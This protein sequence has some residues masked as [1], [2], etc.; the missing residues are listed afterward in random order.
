MG[1]EERIIPEVQDPLDSPPLSRRSFL[2]FPAK[3]TARAAFS[4]I[5]KPWGFLEAV[6]K[7]AA[8]KIVGRR[9]VVIGMIAFAALGDAIGVALR[10]DPELAQDA[11]LRVELNSVWDEVQELQHPF[12]HQELLDKVYNAFTPIQLTGEELDSTI[13]VDDEDSEG[14]P[15]GKRRNSYG[16]NQPYSW[17]IVAAEKLTAGLR[18]LGRKGTVKGYDFAQPG[19]SIRGITGPEDPEGNVQLGA[20]TADDMAA[21]LPGEPT[22]TYVMTNHKGFLAAGC[23]IHGDDMRDTADRLLYYLDP[24]SENYNADFADFIN[25]PAKSK[26]KN[27][28]VLRILKE[29]LTLYKNDKIRIKTGFKKAL[30]DYE[31]INSDR[32]VAQNGRMVLVV[33]QPPA[34][35]EYERIPYVPLGSPRGETG[36]LDTTKYG[37]AGRLAALWTMTPFYVLEGPMLEEFSKRTGI[38]VTSTPLL[39]MQIPKDHLAPDSHLNILGHED[40]ANAVVGLFQVTDG[41]VS[42]AF[43]KDGSPQTL[44][45]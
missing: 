33:S 38:P 39:A 26:L 11:K 23:G 34:L 8:E 21:D 37:P 24:E 17:P 4:F 32:V 36:T 30:D 16:P 10:T 14:V 19:A 40:R 13:F 20:K 7:G 27:E 9:K 3:E 6:I 1:S 22:P 44:A 12:T 43:Q 35:D 2:K 25:D 31:K 41:N 15:D 5:E 45:A 28:T 18:M 42:L 29:V